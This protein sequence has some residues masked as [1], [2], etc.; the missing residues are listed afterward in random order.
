MNLALFD[1]DN[2]A[3]ARMKAPGDGNAATLASHV[4]STPRRVAAE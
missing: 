4:R 2:L 1:V 3:Q